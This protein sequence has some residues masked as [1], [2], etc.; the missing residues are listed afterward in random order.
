MKIN[1]ATAVKI[2][3]PCTRK[4]QLIDDSYCLGCKRTWQQIKNWCSYSESE[5]LE[6]MQ[7]LKR[8]TIDKPTMNWQ[9]FF[10]SAGKGDKP[11][12]CFSKD[13]KSNYDN[14]NWGKKKPINDE[15]VFSKKT[16]TKLRK[17]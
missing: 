4:C 9:A 3:T 2:S 15:K 5:R 17:S 14:I 7:N 11:R 12:N 6:I 13:Y 1:E 10:M 16:E 8:K